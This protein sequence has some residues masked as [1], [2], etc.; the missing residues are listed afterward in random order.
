MQAL[1]GVNF[2]YL[3]EGQ[4][5]RQHGLIYENGTGNWD[6]FGNHVLLALAGP[7]QPSNFSWPGYGGCLHTPLPGISLFASGVGN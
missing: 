2:L 4:G 6:S 5:P 1:C 3:C 7:H